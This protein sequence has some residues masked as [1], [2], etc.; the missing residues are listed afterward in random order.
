MTTYRYMGPDETAA[1]GAAQVT[2]GQTFEEADD[3]VVEAA[4][5]AGLQIESLTAASPAAE[6][7][8]VAEGVFD[9]LGTLAQPV[10]GNPAAGLHA[11]LAQDFVDLSAADMGVHGA[12][13]QNFAADYGGAVPAPAEV[14][15]AEPAAEE[16]PPA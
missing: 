8:P 16:A 12:L 10:Q 1:I 6:A 15:A 14:P 5:Q 4:R 2:Q 13:E 11:A 3:A 7:T 9:P